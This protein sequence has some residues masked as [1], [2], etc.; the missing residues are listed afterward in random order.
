MT[1]WTNTK[2]RH[3]TRSG[4]A[5]HREL[6]ERPCKECV[7]AQSAYDKRRLMSEDAKVKNRLRASAQQSAL[8]ALSHLHPET[9]RGL[10]RAELGKRGLA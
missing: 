2:R 10:Y 3:G 9:Y 4:Y 5:L 1:D 8:L 7:A 6:G